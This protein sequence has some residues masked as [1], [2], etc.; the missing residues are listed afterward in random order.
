MDYFVLFDSRVR[1]RKSELLFET[2]SP[3]TARVAMKNE[4]TFVASVLLEGVAKR[5]K[6]IDAQAAEYVPC[7]CRARGACMYRLV[8]RNNVMISLLGSKQQR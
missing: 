6:R 4:T 7:S 3:L 2:F 8:D 1:G 5:T